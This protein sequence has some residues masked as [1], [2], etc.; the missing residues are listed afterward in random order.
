MKKVYNLYLDESGTRHPDHSQGNAP[1]HGYDWFAVGGVLVNEADEEEVRNLYAQFTEKWDIST[2]LHSS[3]IRAQKNNFAWLYKLPKIEQDEFYEE[4]YLLMRD[5]PLTGIACVIDRPRYNIRY[6]ETYGDKQWL[7]CKTAFNIVVERAT[8]VA[9]Y[10]DAAIRIFPEE[11]NKKE[12][13]FIKG[14]YDLLKSSGMPFSETSSERYGP[15]QAVDFKSSLYDLKF[16]K[17]SSPLIQLADLFL[18]PMCM[19]GYDTNNR[20][21][22]R[23]LEDQKLLA[24]NIGTAEAPYLIETKYSC[25]D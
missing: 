12:D 11:C 1:Q 23:L 4:L 6:K 20:P 8:K 13:Q 15:L 2:P 14:Y 10:N 16:K 25:F 9:R 5:C 22:K 24:V 19:G 18:W 7:L 3:E 21:Y 17:K